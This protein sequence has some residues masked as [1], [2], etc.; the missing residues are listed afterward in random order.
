MEI[1]GATVVITG[2]S[3]NGSHNGKVAVDP[4][5]NIAHGIFLDFGVV[6]IIEPRRPMCP[7]FAFPSIERELGG[8]E[9]LQPGMVLRV[10]GVSPSIGQRYEFGG[11]RVE[12]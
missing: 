4:R 11:G 1:E 7:H 3:T 9:G 2:P 8:H 12:R 5:A 6:E 10:D